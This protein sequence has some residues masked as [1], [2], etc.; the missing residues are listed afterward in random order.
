MDASIAP[1]SGFRLLAAGQ[2]LSWFG[3]AFAPIALAVAVIA[4]GG[5]ASEL[6]LVLAATMT[7]RLAGTLVGGV[8]ADRL[9]PARIMVASDIVRALST[10][11]TAGYFAT[12]QDSLL[13]LCGLA[14]VT[15]GAAAFF[16]PAFVSLRPLLVAVERR[17]AANATLNIL[18]NG[19]F[20]FFKY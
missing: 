3:D 19:A 1:S 8:W 11:A 16:G 20:F 15:G 17:H 2:G 4:G 18:H 9:S 7:A 14:A 5:S 6:G 12:G 13:V 10:L